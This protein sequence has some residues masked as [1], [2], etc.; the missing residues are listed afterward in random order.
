[1]K[2]ITRKMFYAGVVMATS[3]VNFSCDADEI[4]NELIAD[5]CN[6]TWTATVAPQV[7]ALNAANLAYSNE[8]TTTNCENRRTAEMN[9]L[10]ALEDVRECVDNLNRSAYDAALIEVR[11]GLAMNDC[12]D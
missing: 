8:P 12:S 7:D 4:V 11:E 6:E 1:M 2:K 3:L 9:Y 5:Q 10:E